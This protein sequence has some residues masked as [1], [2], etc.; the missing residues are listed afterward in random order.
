MV[1]IRLLIFDI[2]FTA[3]S[4]HGLKISDWIPTST[5]PYHRA[6]ACSCRRREKATYRGIICIKYF[7][8]PIAA[9]LVK[10]DPSIYLSLECCFVLFLESVSYRNLSLKKKDMSKNLCDLLLRYNSIQ[11]HNKI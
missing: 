5:N 7:F 2:C 10:F 6:W 1:S 11:L 8:A 3:G 4:F 9:F